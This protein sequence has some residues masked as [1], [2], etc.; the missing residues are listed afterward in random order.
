MSVFTVVLQI[1]HAIVGFAFGL[2][3][4]GYL[5]TLV[6]FKELKPLEKITLGFILSICIDII[7]G[8][9]LGYNETTKNI[10]GGITAKNLWILLILISAI[11]SVV[12]VIQEKKQVK[13]LL[14]PYAVKLKKYLK[15]KKPKTTSKPKAKKKSKTS[16][17]S[18][19]KVSSNPKTKKKAKP[20]KKTI[21]K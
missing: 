10:T 15:N 6:F 9:I 16:K 8:L 18:K 3:I 7:V 2:F 11:L 5:A 1:L 19:S 21:K 20:K 12:L 4:P 17:K 14:K 13:K